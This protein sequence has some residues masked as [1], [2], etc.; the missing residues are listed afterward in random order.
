M[1]VTETGVELKQSGEIV[2]FN[3]ADLMSME[4]KSVE[5]LPP[6]KTRVL[7]AN[8]SRL[9]V[10]E[11]RIDGNEIFIELRRQPVL[12]LPLNQVKAIRFRK[13]SAATDP[14][15]LGMLDTPSRGDRMVIRRSNDRLDPTDGIIKGIADGKVAFDLD[16]DVISAPI[17][18]LEGIIFGGNKPVAEQSNITITDTYGSTW[19]ASELLPSKLDQADAD[20][21]NAN[22]GLR[23]QMNGKVQHTIPIDLVWMVRWSSGLFM[24]AE[25]KPAEQ[26]VQ[27]EFTID[28]KDDAADKWFGP[29]RPAA[30]PT[31]SAQPSQDLILYGGSEVQYR[32]K[33]GFRLLTGSV[34]RSSEIKNAGGVTVRIKMDD[35]VVWENDLPN[36]DPL[37]FELELNKARR[38]KFEIDSGDDGDL[39][40]VVRLVRPRFV[41]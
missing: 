16:G 22:Q 41:K 7:L 23:L 30:K 33:D 11:V 37:G 27:T 10:D 26:S 38:I 29:Q 35:Q 18:R 34:R 9:A 40:A 20:Q 8:G 12:T 31:S 32:V 1:A 25:A 36:A 28:W 14:V 24:L 17:N 5:K 15:W 19:A 2:Q 6:S 3:I 4:M 21:P 13:S 39:G